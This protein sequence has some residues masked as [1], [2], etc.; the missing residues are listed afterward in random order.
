M[1]DEA[2]AV[3]EAL[4]RRGLGVPARL[5]LEALGPFRPLI[6]A[7][8]TFGSGL[9]PIPRTAIDAVTSDAAWENFASVIENDRDGCPTSEG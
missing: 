3:A 1:S 2:R 7:G 5:A 9:L 6:G 8:I 4:R